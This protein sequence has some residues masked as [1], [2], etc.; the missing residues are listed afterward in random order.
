M[1]DESEILE[2]VQEKGYCYVEDVEEEFC[3]GDRELAA[4]IITAAK[5]KYKLE[6]LLMNGHRILQQRKSSKVEDPEPV[7]APAPASERPSILVKKVSTVSSEANRLYKICRAR[8][9]EIPVKVRELPAWVKKNHPELLQVGDGRKKPKVKEERPVKKKRPV[10][11]TSSN[12]PGITET[13]TEPLIYGGPRL[14]KEIRIYEVFFSGPELQ[15]ISAALKGNGG[16]RLA[17]EID[18]L[19]EGQHA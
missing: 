7:P 13:K 4:D 8:K 10:K 11:K 18:A 15:E 2:R 16:G 6:E 17:Q 12:T 9:I 19:L 5:T 14:V 1:A 3:D